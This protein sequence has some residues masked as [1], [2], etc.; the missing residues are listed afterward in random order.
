MF[1]STKLL[2]FTWSLNRLFCVVPFNVIKPWPNGDASQRKFGKRTCVR[3]LA[4]GG[5]TELHIAQVQHK[6]AKKPFQCSLVR[7]S[8]QRKTIV[9]PTWTTCVGWPN[10][11]KFA[12]TCVQIWARSKWSQV[13]ASTR[14]SWPKGVASNGNFSTCDS[15]WF[16]L[17]RAFLE[18]LRHHCL[19]YATFITTQTHYLQYCYKLTTTEIT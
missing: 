2:T 4:M 13:N 3:T 17:A 11:Q 18:R 12:F 1:A 6:L 10:G 8:V 5:Q 9:E 19:F 14:K 16:R 15:L 7:A